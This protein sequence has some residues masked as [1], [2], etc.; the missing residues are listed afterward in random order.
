MISANAIMDRCLEE[1]FAA[2]GVADAQGSRYGQQLR[3]WLEQGRHGDMQWLEEHVE[4]RIDPRVLVP[5]AQSVIVVAD[6]YDGAP[7]EAVPE[8]GGRIA[9]YARGRDYHTF[10][11]KRL[12]RVADTLSE[13]YPGETFRACVDTAPILEREVAAAAGLGAIG[14]HTLLIEPS[15]GSWLLLGEIV[16]TLAIEPTGTHQDLDP[17]GACTR[18][19]D[20]CPT[21]AIKPWSVDATRC[22]SYLTIEHRSPINPDFFEGIGDWLFGCDICQEVCPHNQP[23]DHTR[24]QPT[25]PAYD[26]RSRSHDASGTSLDVM[27]VLNWTEEDRR[28]AFTTSAMKRAKLDMIRRNA[29]IVAGNQ[30]RREDDPPLRE[31][32]VRI[33]ADQNEP[34]LVREAAVNVLNVR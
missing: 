14:K 18:C 1:G 23:T 31:C 12:H 30:L 22:V 34:P 8:R 4:L 26:A 25:E 3:A 24:T 20:A 15:I 2:A 6:R 16:T 7:D 29:V 28:E 21:E 27:A 5:G 11:K 32:L 13:Q 9:R 33:A 17:C 10:M 19:I